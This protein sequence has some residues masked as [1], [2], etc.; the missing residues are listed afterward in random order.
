LNE[1]EKPN[2]LPYPPGDVSTVKACIVHLVGS[3]VAY[4]EDF[5]KGIISLE[6][7][8]NNMFHYPIFAFHFNLNDEEMAR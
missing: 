4:K 1:L 7:Q 2:G 3:G 5:K 8:F 6:K